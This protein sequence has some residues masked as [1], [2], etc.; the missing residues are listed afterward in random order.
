MRSF[1]TYTDVAEAIREA[2]G[3]KYHVVGWVQEQN[4]WTVYDPTKDWT[5]LGVDPEF[6][7]LQ[8]GTLP[9]PLN[10]TAFDVLASVIASL[11]ERD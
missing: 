9:L 11:R 7:C 10:K 3:L 2:N 8:S 1:K 5:L 6:L 4:G